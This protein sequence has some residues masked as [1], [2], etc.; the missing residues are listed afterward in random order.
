MDDM[1]LHIEN[2]ENSTKKLF[3]IANEYS[4]V[5]GYKV[6]MLKSVV[7]LYAND[8]LAESE[9]KKIISFT[10]ATE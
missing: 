5:A 1:I 3:E 6:S 9:I 7:F 2:P 10:I 4:K 8:E